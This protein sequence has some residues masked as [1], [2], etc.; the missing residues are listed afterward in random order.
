MMETVNDAF[1]RAYE[2]MLTL[3]NVR[4]ICEACWGYGVISYANTGTWKSWL[5]PGSGM[6]TG[7]GFTKDVCY[8]CWGS[9]DEKR[10]WPSW[11]K[12]K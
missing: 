12:E 3:R 2:K 11:D 4:D 6:I 5:H 9:G 7:Q 1:N 10:P 8:K